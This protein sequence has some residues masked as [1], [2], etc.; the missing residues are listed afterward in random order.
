MP[1]Q[2]KQILKQRKDGRY[3][4]KYKGIQFMGATSDEALEARQQYIDGLKYGTHISQQYIGAYALPWLKRTKV[5][6][7]FHTYNSAAILLEKLLKHIGNKRFDEIVPS[8]IK[9]IYSI[10]FD[11][12]SNEYIRKAAMLYRSLFDAALADGLCRFNPAREKSAKPHKGTIGGHRSITP[13]ERQW[14]NTLCT[15]HRAFPAV[16]AML[17]E[18]LR[19]PEAKAL[20]LSSVDLASGT[21]RVISFAH[22]S[23]HGRYE[24]TAIG[25]TQK[26]TR[27]IPLFAPFRDAVKGKTGPLVPAVHGTLTETAWRALW[28]SYV[29]NM[30][31]AING[32]QKRWYGRTREHKA[33][34]ASGG[35]LPPWVSFTVRPYDLRH[36]FC[37]ACR[38]AGVELNTCVKWMGHSDAKMVLQIY[39]FVSPARQKSEAEKLETA[40]FSMQNGMQF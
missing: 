1:R 13:Q 11:G 10:E 22:K 5:G 18:G 8:D 20:D 23:K 38:D 25:K 9:T 4:C 17:Y 15:D 35:T 12:M 2:K 28:A 34:L 24:I 39:D 37:T 33:I 14:I 7:S 30:E 40:L 3:C 6:V 27:E 19:P 32:M 31:A 29:S 16:M 26:S 36:S 21:L